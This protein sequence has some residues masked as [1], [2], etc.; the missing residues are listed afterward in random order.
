MAGCVKQCILTEICEIQ[1][2]Q[3]SPTFIECLS[4]DP[5]FVAQTTPVRILIPRRFS[6]RTRLSPEATSSCVGMTVHVP[7]GGHD[8]SP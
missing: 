3:F 5:C 6:A 7:P 1:H 8:C 4:T 2:Y